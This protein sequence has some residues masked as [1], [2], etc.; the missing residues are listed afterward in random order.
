M[1]VNLSRIDP[2]EETNQL[3]GWPTYAQ[4]LCD[5]PF[6][7]SRSWRSSVCS[8]MVDDIVVHPQF[9]HLAVWQLSAMQL[10]DRVY[11]GPPNNFYLGHQTAFS[12]LCHQ[13]VCSMSPDTRS[14]SPGNMFFVNRESV[15]CRRAVC[16]TCISPGSFLNYNIGASGRHPV[17]PNAQLRWSSRCYI[18]HRCAATV[19]FF[20]LYT[21]AGDSHVRQN[22]LFIPR[23]RCSPCFISGRYLVNR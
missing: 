19:H 14:M 10:N 11:H 17:S 22:I 5:T 2:G 12:I 4:L 15:L 3:E 21:A 1:I 7:Y 20:V 9:I 23:P 18:S 16:S 6:F 8:D 13:E